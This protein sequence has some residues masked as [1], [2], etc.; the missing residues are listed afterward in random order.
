MKPITLFLI[1]VL[2][3]TVVS[4]QDV[5][6]I[7]SARLEK[8]RRHD[9]TPQQLAI[10]LTDKKESD[11][12]KFD[13]LFSWVLL[14]LGSERCA[15]IS[16]TRDTLRSASHILKRRR[17]QPVD[18]C[19][20]MDSLCSYAGLPST[21]VR[22]YTKDILF[23]VNDS[24][25][26]NSHVWNAVKLDNLWYVYDVNKTAGILRLEL[27]R[28]SKIILKWKQK[29][30]AKK[31]Y[32]NYSFKAKKTKFCQNSSEIHTVRVMSLGPIRAFILRQLEKFNLKSEFVFD[33][34]LTTNF[35]LADPEVF[36]RTHFPVLNYWSLLGSKT[37]VKDFSGD[38]SYYYLFQTLN[39]GQSRQG[40]NCS[41]CDS[42]L[43]LDNLSKHRHV[44]K[45]S[46]ENNPKNN[47]ML[48][49]T[50]FGIAKEIFAQADL[51]Q[52]SLT[53]VS[54]LDTSLAYL[55]L[56]KEHLYRNFSDVFTDWQVHNTKNYVKGQIHH[57]TN[58]RNETAIRS[59]E[60]TTK[61]QTRKLGYYFKLVQRYNVKYAKQYF[62]FT[63]TDTSINRAA[64]PPLSGTLL[65]ETNHKLQIANRKSDSLNLL[66]AGMWGD[67]E[68]I[69]SALSE[70]MWSKLEVLDSLKA[71]CKLI[72]DLRKFYAYDHYT[73]LL[74]DL[75][76]EIQQ[77]IK[78]Y[79]ND[80][81]L[82]VFDVS[83]SAAKLGTDLLAAIETRNRSHIERAAVL[84]EM[85]DHG[86]F[87]LDTLKPFISRGSHEIEQ[88]ACRTIYGNSM[89]VSVMK[90]YKKFYET[91]KSIQHVIQRDKWSEF[92]RH[93]LI[94]SLII[95]RR[96]AYK[97]MPAENVVITRR[98]TMRVT[99]YKSNYLKELK[100]ARR[101][102]AKE[103]AD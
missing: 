12:E 52:D 28:F 58:K 17:A 74:V 49:H 59:I 21:T 39:D 43:A 25:Y 61:E 94:N 83:D 40:V 99:K 87:S 15:N 92:R 79:F 103:K 80:I 81:Q 72:S 47:V 30:E 66:I 8:A 73:K 23:N 98:L 77:Q 89:Q 67:Y 63:K 34:S 11:K 55:G 53:K 45:E 35:Y 85:V 14:N 38:S 41:M 100:K 62:K 29:I 96:R 33:N 54:L 78:S 27:T 90:A 50:N 64:K 88:D 65:E 1:L 46:F 93:T 36:A 102:A 16:T 101:L 76:L 48:W 44:K 71:S 18:L 69:F 95:S 75:D 24:V 7:D 37:N 10:W 97:S 3:Y 84:R 19:T 26:I 20:M 31:K 57:A 2:C 68:G 51:A 5:L 91:E 56:A 60:A 4:A 6:K 42:Y 13:V 22:G 32:Y 70:N 9:K 82:K 86:H